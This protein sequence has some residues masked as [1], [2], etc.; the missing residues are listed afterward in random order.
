MGLET[1]QFIPD[2]IDANPDGTDPKSE[3]D[4]HL[5]LIKTCVQGSFP[6]FVGTQAVPA[7]VSLTEDQIND[8]VRQSDPALITAPWLHD[9]DLA[10]GND[11]S[12]LGIDTGAT[13]RRLAQLNSSD[14][15]AFGDG[16]V[17]AESRALAAWDMF[18]NATPAG[19][20]VDPS[21]GSLL[22]RDRDLSS[23]KAG[24]R[25]PKTVVQ[26]ANFTTTQDVEGVVFRCTGATLEITMAELEL[27]TTFRL[28][29]TAGS[30]QVLKGAL[31]LMRFMDGD[32]GM[33][34]ATNGV[35]LQI[36]SV[37]ELFFADVVTTVYVFGTGIS[38]F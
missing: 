2:L 34:E 23:R 37:A 33:I 1:G 28:L 14:V 8:S 22:V 4:N 30:T 24:F 16:A 9:E 6:A 11:F 17:D 29:V 21:L 15:A 31:N 13:A 20:W 26:S 27:G 3:G 35:Q 10:I 36:G 18:I 12:L 5:R 25:N 19:R 7:S 38:D 32:G